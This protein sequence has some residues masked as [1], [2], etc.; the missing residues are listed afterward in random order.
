[1]WKKGTEM[2][3]I[4]LC[5]WW[6]VM[7]SWNISFIQDFFFFPWTIN[8]L[9]ENKA[10]QYSSGALFSTDQFGVKISC[11]SCWSSHGWCKYFS[12]LHFTKWSKLEIITCINLC[13]CSLEFYGR[14][15]NDKIV[16]VSCY[17]L[18]KPLGDTKET[19]HWEKVAQRAVKSRIL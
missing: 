8:Y 17:S 9:K 15:V 7:P 6:G 14:T 11:Q 5:R 16:S 10:L 13:G 3:T 19:V 18:K 1:M 12:L 4:Q 2:K